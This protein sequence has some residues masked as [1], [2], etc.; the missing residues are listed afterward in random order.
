MLYLNESSHSNR[1][2]EFAV[3]FINHSF[4]VFE[5]L[6]F[7]LSMLQSNGPKKWGEFMHPFHGKPPIDKDY[8]L[9]PLKLIHNS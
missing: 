3:S 4:I 5:E 1:K 8:L 2:E 6:L 7:L 9:T